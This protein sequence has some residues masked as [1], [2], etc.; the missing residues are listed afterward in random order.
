MAQGTRAS[1]LKEAKQV[2]RR[3]GSGFPRVSS[4]LP[5]KWAHTEP[6][7]QVPDGGNGPFVSSGQQGAPG[8]VSGPGAGRPP[9]ESGQRSAHREAGTVR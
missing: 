3:M 6:S 2:T 4:S 7:S 5:V 8:E 1:S 9:R